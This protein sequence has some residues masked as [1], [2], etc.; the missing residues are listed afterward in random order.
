MSE[1]MVEFDHVWKKFKKGEIY[2]SLRDL[3]PAVARLVISSNHRGELREREFWAVKDVSFEV[4]RGEALGIVGPNGAGKSTI[5]KLLS[6]IL[7]PTMGNVQIR[8]RL[9]ALIEV[10]AGFHPD[11][12]GKE[13]IYLNGAIL[14]MKKDEVNRKMEQILEFSGLSD[15]IDTPVK[16]YSSGM[17]ARLGFSVAAHV[18]PEVLL[19]DEVLSVGDFPFQRKCIKRMKETLQN[20]TTVVYISHN[21]P[22]VIDLCPQAILLND[23]QIRK[24]G[25]SADVCR[26]Y[27]RAY[28]E[29]HRAPTSIRLDSVELVSMQGTPCHTFKAADWAL[30]RLT[31]T[32]ENALD[33]VRM[34]FFVKRRDGLILFD[35]SSENSARKYYSF[36]KDQTQ[37]VEIGFRV[38]LPT[39]TYFLGVNFWS[40]NSDFYMYE[41][42][43]VELHV[44]ADMFQGYTFVDTRWE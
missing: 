37:S 31:V 16:R 23:G 5:L 2:D 15:F 41:D 9:S 38:N 22:S 6:G 35:T 14:G 40:A 32:S 34:G 33:N 7:R 28:A 8:G 18:D 20:G 30:L 13:N 26:F 1:M 36:Q 10:G 29:A 21:L 25:T 43:T 11:L 44:Q 19:V 39:G 17:Y 24:T 27:Y 12:T 4:S 42:E 3:I